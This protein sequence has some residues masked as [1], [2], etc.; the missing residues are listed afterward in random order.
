MLNFLLF[1][2]KGDL[3][4]LTN[5]R[6]LS[7]LNAESK[8]FESF[9]FKHIFDHLRDNNSLIPLQS[10]FSPDD[11]TVNQLTFL[12]DTFSRALD[13]EKEIRVVF[14][15]VK[16]ALIVSGM[17]DSYINLK[18]AVF[19]ILFLIDLRIIYL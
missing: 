12:Y 3:C 4:L 2:Q 13:D 15:D 16:K 9:V 8:V 1:P 5:H 17:Q 19:Q 11:S 6:P 14:C 10:G 7:R 18:H